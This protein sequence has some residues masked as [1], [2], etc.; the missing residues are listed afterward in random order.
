MRQPQGFGRAVGAGA[1]H[2]LD[3]AG[4][5]LDDRSDDPL[6]LFVAQRGALA[7]G[8]HRAEAGRAGGDL[9]L[10]LLAQLVVVDARITKR[11]RDR[12]RQ[13]GKRFTLGS[14]NGRSRRLVMR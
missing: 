11:R 6:V 9:E 3:P 13:P 1:G 7:R 2:D 14:H 12:H 10:D 4:R 8:A 5:K